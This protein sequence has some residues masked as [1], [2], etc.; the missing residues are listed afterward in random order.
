MK[1]I[2]QISEEQAREMLKLYEIVF[3]GNGLENRNVAVWKEHG[4]IKEELEKESLLVSSFNSSCKNNNLNC[5]AEKFYN[6]KEIIDRI[7]S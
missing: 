7:K 6:K 4:F 2:I 5:V 1:E 3:D